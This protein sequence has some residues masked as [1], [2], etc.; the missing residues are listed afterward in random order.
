MHHEH[1]PAGLCLKAFTIW[2]AEDASDSSLAYWM[3]DNDFSNAQG[4]SARP[5]SKHA[6]KWVSSLHRY[7]AF[8][9]AD[10]R[11]PRENTRNLTTLPTSERRLGQWGRYQRR[12]EENLCRY[13]EIRLD[14]SPAFKW[15]PHEEG[16]RAR[17]DACTN[18]RS[19][20][21]RVPYLNSNDP[22]E[23]ALA[24]W[25]GRQMRQ[26]QRGTLMATRAARLKAFIAEGPTI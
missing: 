22:I 18:H 4:I 9:R 1:T 2:Q 3:V 16:W 21:G 23:F 19:S 26:L 5:H 14:V 20:T 7:E 13:Q 12:F 25:L 24:R 8:W 11:S 17:F 6:V 10:G 15:D